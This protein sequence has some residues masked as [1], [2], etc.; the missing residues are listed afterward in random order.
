MYIDGFTSAKRTVELSVTSGEDGESVQSQLRLRLAL[1][2]EHLAY[3]I[4]KVTIVE[5]EIRRL[6]SE[7]RDYGG[8]A[9][10]PDCRAN[11]SCI[12]SSSACRRPLN[13]C[14]QIQ[15]QA[16]GGGSARRRHLQRKTRSVA[17]KYLT[18]SH[19]SSAGTADLGD[20]STVE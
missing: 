12:W 3:S 7:I 20:T 14:S 18:F 1:L 11:S 4:H 9:S 8:N 16:R 5:Q 17:R 19:C 6:M 2:F 10:K 15:R 13:G